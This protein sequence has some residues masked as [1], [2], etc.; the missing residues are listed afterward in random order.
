MREQKATDADLEKFREP[1][2]STHCIA[3]TIRWTFWHKINV[4]IGLAM[5]FAEICANTR[6]SRGVNAPMTAGADSLMFVV[7]RHK[8]KNICTVL[9][10]CIWEQKATDA[11]LEKFREP[12]HPAP[13]G[14]D[15][16]FSRALSLLVYLSRALSFN[17]LLSRSLS[18]NISFAFSPGEVP[19]AQPPRTRRRRC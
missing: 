18:R 19:G 2:H 12:N 5:Y 13:D 8:F 6:A 17:A 10:Q 4:K 3:V 14:D 7:R 9:S 15:A 16:R 11:D 1:N